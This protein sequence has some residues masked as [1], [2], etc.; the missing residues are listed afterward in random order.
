MVPILTQQLYAAKAQAKIMAGLCGD[1]AARIED[2][3]DHVN[4]LE[5]ELADAMAELREMKR[6]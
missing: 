6:A 5:S 1:A 3:E 4:W 2:L